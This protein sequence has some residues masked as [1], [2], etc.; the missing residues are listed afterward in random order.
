MKKMVIGTS[1]KTQSQLLPKGPCHNL[2][3]C[4]QVCI[5]TYTHRTIQPGIHTYTHTHKTDNT[6]TH[7]T[8]RYKDT[9]AQYIVPIK[10]P[11]LSIGTKS[12]SNRA[13]GD[14]ERDDLVTG[15]GRLLA[16]ELGHLES[17]ELVRVASAD[18]SPGS[19]QQQATV[20]HGDTKPGTEGDPRACLFA[21]VSGDDVWWRRDGR[22][23][24]ADVVARARD[25]ARARERRERE[26]REK[27]TRERD[28]R[29]ERE[30]DE[31][32]R[33]RDE[34]ERERE[35]DRRE[36]KRREREMR[37]ERERD[38]RE[39]DVR[40]RERAREREERERDE[41][42]RERGERER[43]ER[44]RERERREPQQLFVSALTSWSGGGPQQASSSGRIPDDSANEQ[45]LGERIIKRQLR[46]N[47]LGEA[48]TQHR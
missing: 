48:H 32:E 19:Q 41:R 35:R 8:D 28:E 27:E 47:R 14:D 13:G 43:R 45:G 15:H 10:I 44:V 12:R 46:N 39:R 37:E 16:R 30:G 11:S 31:R 29:R 2:H 9:Q 26:E 21:P 3:T 34:R 42:E 7:T 38:E 36:R 18:D 25:R 20:Q 17:E 5:Y 4:M 6:H 33:E 23:H 24:A 1:P 40:E 22:R